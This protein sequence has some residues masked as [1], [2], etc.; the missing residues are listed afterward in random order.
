M[1]KKNGFN[2]MMIMKR[3]DPILYKYTGDV[4]RANLYFHALENK[5]KDKIYSVDYGGSSKTLLTRH[6]VS[7]K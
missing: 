7:G 5:P 4:F 3:Y 1:L 2:D 6:P